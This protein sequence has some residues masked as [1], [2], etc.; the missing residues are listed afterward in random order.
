MSGAAA[1]PAGGPYE[2]HS[3]QGPTPGEEAHRFYPGPE[4]KGGRSWQ[5]P[6]P[7][8]WL[9]ELLGLLARRERAVL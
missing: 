7:W 6:G 5:V 8:T 1:P 2:D 4:A 3:P 9:P